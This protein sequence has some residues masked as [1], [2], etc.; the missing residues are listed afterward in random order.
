MFLKKTKALYMLFFI[1]ILFC[2]QIDIFNQDSKVIIDDKP[3]DSPFLGGLNYPRNQWID[4]DNDNINELMILD[5]DGCL[6]LYEYITPENGLG[7]PF[8]NIIDTSYGNIC[9]MSWFSVEDF[10]QDGDLELACQSLD[11]GNQVHIYDIVANEFTLIGTVIDSNDNPIIS[12]ASMVPTFADIDN[13]GDFDFFTGNVIGTVTFYEN[14]GMEFGLP[15]LNLVSFQWQNIWIT[16]P[17][18]HGASAI[19]FIDIDLDDDLDL[20]WGDYFQR[21]LYFIENVGS[22]ES[23]IMSNDNIVSD[24]PYNDPIYT[25]GRNMPSFNDIDLDG[26]LDLFI[27]VLGGDGGIQLS[28]NFLFYENSDNIFSLK[29]TDFM[30]TIDLNSNVAPKVIDIDSDGD[31]DLF[32]G[33]DYNT[34]SFPIRGRIYFFRNI[35]TDG[36]NIFELEDDEFLGND[37]GNSLVPT[38]ADID[39]DADLDLFIGDYNGNIIFYENIGDS[40]S[41][42][43]I[44]NSNLEG[45]ELNTYISPTF[46][47]IDSDGDLDLF[48][49]GN[50]GML[51]FYRNTGSSSNFNFELVIDSF[52]DID[53]GSRSHPAFIDYDSDG[54]YDLIIGSHNQNIKVYQN[55]GDSFYP[56]YVEFECGSIP[57]Y[58]LNTKPDFYNQNDTIYSLTGISTGG[59]L[60]SRLNYNIGDVNADN[61]IN[62]IDAVIIINYIVGDSELSFCLESGDLNSDQFVDILDIVMLI[63]QIIS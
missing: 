25:T 5:E 29:T 35:G 7:N 44:Y 36:Q 37:I 12:D 28:E 3:I 27:S 11:S 50:S 2:F 57:Y 45:I 33:Q 16:G 59:I 46:V 19:A 43:F 42:N 55:I 63:N 48:A 62:V 4:L 51:H 1:N 52:F 22:S 32:I 15:V 34:S 41:M 18:R 10:N 40:N 53:V 6:R 61:L 58:G 17:S 20:F 14:V 38:F 24:F 30:N 54:D 31:F 26:D 49:G 39:S 21:S 23:P 47:D 9:G 60:A 13:D 56:N 8:F